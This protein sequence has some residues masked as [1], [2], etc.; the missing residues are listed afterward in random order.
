MLEVGIKRTKAM[1]SEF[2]G[3]IDLGYIYTLGSHFVPNLVS[4]FLFSDVK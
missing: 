3:I 4:R 2:S 1:T